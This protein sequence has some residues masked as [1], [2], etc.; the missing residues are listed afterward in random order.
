MDR[1]VFLALWLHYGT[2]HNGKLFQR[3]QEY[4]PDLEEAYVAAQKRQGSAFAKFTPELCARLFEAADPKFMERYIG[5]LARHKIGILALDSPE[6]PELLAEIEDAPPLLFVRGKLPPSPALPIGVI[7]ARACSDHGKLIAK[8]FGF[9]LA[10]SGATV[11]TG[12][13]EG[14]DSYATV[15]ALDCASS[16][17]PA[18]GVLGC[19]ID[20][21][22]P[23]NGKAVFET[24]A[25]RGAIVT[26]FLP[27]TPPIAYHFPLRNRIVSG[28][29]RGILVVEAGERSGCSITAN[30]ALEQG[31][32]VFAVPGRITDPQSIGTNRMIVNGEAKPVACAADILCEYDSAF[33]AVQADTR[34][35]VPFSTLEPRAQAVYHA[36]YTGEKNIDILQ[37]MT[38]ISVSELNSVLTAMQFAG[39]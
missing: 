25:E 10:E 30:L 19:G 18:I 36:L 31:R 2:G 33:L 13:A 9:Q 8:H 34:K 32:D 21:I 4:Y 11:I 6:Y 15:G 26:E 28:L 7:G 3:V 35:S 5:W 24:L 37:E 16:E 27:K 38:G 17:C 39:I 12:L 1:E 22:Y 23:P 20:I 29:S 14:I